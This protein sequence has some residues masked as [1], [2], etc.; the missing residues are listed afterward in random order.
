MLVAR[1]VVDGEIDLA[2][3]LLGVVGEQAQRGKIDRYDLVVNTDK[4]GVDGAAQ[5]IR[6]YVERLDSI[7]NAE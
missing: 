5:V 4:L 1:M 2:L 6:D 3:E 7:R